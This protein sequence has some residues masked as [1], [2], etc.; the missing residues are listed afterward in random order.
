M[1]ML[2]T[3]YFVI[4]EAV[5]QN[6]YDMLTGSLR[7]NW[8]NYL[9]GYSF[10]TNSLP[11]LVSFVKKN[12]AFAEVVSEDEYLLA[13]RLGY[14]NR[15]II[16]NGPYKSESSFREVLLAGGYVN[17]DSRLEISWLTR[18][19]SEYPEQTFSV[20]IRANFDL[21]KMCPGETTMGEISGRFGF[22]YES[23]KFAEALGLIRELHNVTVAGLHL[24]SSS[25]SRSC[26]ICRSIA[27]MACQIPKEFQ[28]SLS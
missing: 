25:K 6:Y 8:N 26:N 12:G 3:P 20:G 21:E 2:Q 4:D 28:L 1:E 27:T 11:W 22:C 9:V 13:R 17:L 24:H 23:G 7:E 19:A 10:K 15:E 18:L 16:Y 14:E 5:L